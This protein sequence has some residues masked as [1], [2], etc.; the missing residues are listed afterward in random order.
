MLWIST[1]CLKDSPLDV[2]LESL[3]SLTRGIEIVDGGLHRI[4]SAS[5]LESFPYKY[6]IRIPQLDINP[7]SILEPVRQSSVAVL[8]ERFAFASEVDA[9]VIVN[10]GFV[11]SPVDLPLAKRQLAKSC[12]DLIHAA[13]EYGVT[14]LFRNMGRW[15]NYLLRFPEELNL[16]S[17]VPL[18]LDIGH[19][20]VNGV[21]PQFLSDG[22]S[23][24]FHLYDCRETS[25]EHLEV[26]KG[27]IN[28]GLVAAAM[29]AHSAR[30][31]Y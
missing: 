11:S 29:Y 27:S 3:G 10:P 12:N 4:P 24:C 7:A 22:A 31:G 5:L 6:S 14:F 16:I 2:T 26:R 15:G 1:C 23:R 25:E 28:F 8:T 20:H 17:Q 9:D 13:N 18:A 30:G 19:A 21:L